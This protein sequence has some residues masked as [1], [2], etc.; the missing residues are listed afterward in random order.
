MQ[1]DDGGVYH[2]VTCTHFPDMVS[3]EAE[4]GGGITKTAAVKDRKK[5]RRQ[6][7]ALRQLKAAVADAEDAILKNER[8]MA[9]LEQTMA[10]P[11]VC[12][13]QE[14]LLELSLAYQREQERTSALYEAL[15]QAED[16]YTKAEAE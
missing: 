14:K 12:R 16:A 2:K 4:T 3:P 9:E 7:A 11:A 6:D 13:N 15:E 5:E 1:R 10:D 8:R